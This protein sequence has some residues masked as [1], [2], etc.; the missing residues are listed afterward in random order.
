MES[1]KVENL[2]W[3]SRLMFTL[4]VGSTQGKKKRG[5]DMIGSAV[6]VCVYRSY[7]P[8]LVGFMAHKEVLPIRQAMLKKCWTNVRQ[9]CP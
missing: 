9:F 1:A 8:R 5:F 4:S 7:A 6:N 2:P 3:G